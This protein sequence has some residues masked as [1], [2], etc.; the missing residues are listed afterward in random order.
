MFLDILND[1]VELV[2]RLCSLR[3]KVYVAREVEP[4]HFLN[5]SYHNS[6]AFGLSHQSKDFGMSRFAEYDNLRIGACVILLFDAALQLQYNGACG[7][8]NLD[9][10]L[11]CHLVGGWRFAMSPEQHFHATE[12]SHV[13]MIDGDEPEALEALTFHSVMND[14]AEAVESLARGKLFFGFLD[15]SGYSEAETTAVVYFY[16]HFL[17]TS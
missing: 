13:I 14:V 17:L 11:A 4:F 15:G 3:V 1:A 10:V 8:D 2:E 5:I 6:L 12:I 7:I 16:L 9:V